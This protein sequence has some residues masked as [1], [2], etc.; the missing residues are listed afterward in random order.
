VNQPSFFPRRGSASMQSNPA[1]SIVEDICG[2]GTTEPM[3]LQLVK[4]TL[5]KKALNSFHDN[6]QAESMSHYDDG[7][8]EAN[9]RRRRAPPGNRPRPFAAVP[10]SVFPPIRRE[11]SPKAQ[12]LPPQPSS[13]DAMSIGSPRSKRTEFIRHR[14]SMAPTRTEVDRARIAA[15]ELGRSRPRSIDSTLEPAC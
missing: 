9:F 1:Q 15:G 7:T 5:T 3:P 8:R 14:R 6:F 12:A 13:P 4:S 2:I 11:S 10:P